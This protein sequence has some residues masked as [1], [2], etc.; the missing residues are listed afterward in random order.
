M[1]VDT[2]AIIETLIAG[3]EAGKIAAQL[4]NA[5]PPRVTL[6]TVIY[7]ATVVLASKRNI[8]VVDAEQIIRDFLN[9]FDISIVP[10]TDRI[11]SL[12]IDAFARYGKGRHPAKLNFG[13][14]FSYAGARAAGL[15]LLYVGND[16][17]LTDLAKD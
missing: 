5:T 1:V 11:A 16:F 15:P 4:E 12:A 17:S 7:E 13:D 2:S 6:P 10:I 14:C 9:D 8:A 3:P